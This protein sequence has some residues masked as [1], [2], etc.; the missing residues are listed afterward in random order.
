M[1]FVEALF[2]SIGGALLGAGLSVALSML[3]KTSLDF[4]AISGFMLAVGVFLSWLITTA[5]TILP[6]IQASKI[7]AAEA[8][9]YE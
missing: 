2:V 1:F 8:I 4:A 6:S 5:L 7:P 9:R 3:M